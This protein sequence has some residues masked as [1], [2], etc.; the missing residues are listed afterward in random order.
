MK[1]KKNHSGGDGYVSNVNE[2]IG[3]K[4]AITR[5]SSNY[6]P[7]FDGDLLQNGGDGYSMDVCADVGGQP[8]VKRYTPLHYPI[9]DGSLL[10]TAGNKDDQ[11]VL[12]TVHQYGGKNKKNINQIFAVQKIA[13]VLSPLDV[14]TL[15]K[16]MY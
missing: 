15:K 5:Y 8:V 3:G 14:K 13:H 6:R 1:S 12:N 2:S 9:F 4:I 16:N 10:Q 11:F 7:I